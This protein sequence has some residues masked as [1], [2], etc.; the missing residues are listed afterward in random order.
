MKKF[1]VLLLAGL[2]TFSITACADKTEE[3]QTGTDS[4]F[5]LE[6]TIKDKI[7]DKKVIIGIE[8]TVKP[9]MVF[10]AVIEEFYSDRR[11]SYYFGS[12]ISSYIIVTYD[13]NTT[14]N[15]KD[16]LANGHI[17]I[18]DLDEYHISYHRELIRKSGN[19]KDN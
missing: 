19:N 12:P 17:D 11:F 5:I 4:G 6:D 14:E 18:R 16:A 8:N 7:K 13:D 9:D 15:V 3:K 10:P 2:M 1:L